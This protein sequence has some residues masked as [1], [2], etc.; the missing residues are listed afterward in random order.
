[1]T[2]SNTA[3][4]L[5][6]IKNGDYT[7][8]TPF[9]QPPLINGFS[10]RELVCA[11]ENLGKE[12]GRIERQQENQEMIE[13]LLD[14]YNIVHGSGMGEMIFALR[15]EL[16]T[17][18]LLDR[19]SGGS[20]QEL[21]QNID[22]YGISKINS[23]FEYLEDNGGGIESLESRLMPEGMMWP[24]FE[25]GEPVKVGDEF[26]RH[27]ETVRIVA[28]HYAASSCYLNEAGGRQYYYDAPLKCSEPKHETMQDVIDDC[29]KTYYE[30]WKCRHATCS[31]CP[32]PIEGK[33]P[34]K[35][36]NVDYCR[37]AQTR[38]IKRRLEA[39]QERMGGEE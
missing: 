29:G 28:I 30:Y 9:G 4:E 2:T 15:Q 3:F 20:F 8:E 21:I 34:F 39:I 24:R 18:H 5:Q 31:E 13:H 37:E 35:Y 26:E 19:V 22:K 17:I 16:N 6:R 23:L 12:I 10:A 27:G 25:D 32:S 38:D 1:M 11:A 33:K 36:Y 7:V 14:Q